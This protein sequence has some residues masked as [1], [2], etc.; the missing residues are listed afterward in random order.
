MV[1]TPGV[2]AGFTT[3]FSQASPLSVAHE[4]NSIEGDG[5]ASLTRPPPR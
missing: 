1:G 3:A 4:D 5:R 2:A